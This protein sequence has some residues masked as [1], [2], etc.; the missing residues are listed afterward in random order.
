MIA[1]TAG[2]LR[3]SDTDDYDENDV[4]GA[5]EGAS[6]DAPVRRE[7]EMSLNLVRGL[8][9]HQPSHSV[10]TNQA[11]ARTSLPPTNPRRTQHSAQTCSA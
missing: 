7:H 8:T 11:S 10:M 4:E 1:A 2:G 3:D 9:N 6:I 5:V